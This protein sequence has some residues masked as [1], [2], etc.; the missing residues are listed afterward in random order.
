MAAT[1]IEPGDLERTVRKLALAGGEFADAF[2]EETS[3]AT[4]TFE[5]GKVDKIRRGIDRGVGLRII[6]DRRTLYAYSSE[7]SV[8]ALDEMAGILLSAGRSGLNRT[9][10]VFSA[11]AVN[12][13]S[14]I[15]LNPLSVELAK[16]IALL[17][18]ADEVARSFGEEITQVRC[19]FG[20][21]R[22]RVIQ[23]NSDGMTLEFDRVGLVFVVHVTARRGDLLQTGYEPVGGQVGWELFDRTSPT[24]IASLAASRALMMLAAQQA[25]SGRMPVVLHSDAG[26]TMIHEA[27]GHGLEADFI[28]E[29]MSV[30]A[31]SLG[32]RVASEVVSVADDPTLPNRRGSYPF[33][34]EGTRSQRT[35][36]VEN[37][38]LKGFL[39][40]RLS[41]LKQDTTPTGNGRRES[42]RHKPIPRMSNTMILP[43]TTNP[44]E[45]IRATPT[46]LLVKKMGGGQVDP[47]NGNFVFEVSEGYLIE[48]G[49]QGAPVRGATLVGN[50]PK[51]L[52]SID[53]VGNDL[54]FA[55]G[56]CGKDGQGVPVSD[57]QPTVRI[58]TPDNPDTWI[59][60]GGTS[61]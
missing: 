19:V 9:E 11:A 28:V 36:L 6:R 54:G 23:A 4:L 16:K 10:S 12:P 18:E 24:Q 43:G 1:P 45:I 52:Q 50:G 14:T 5:H 37:G 8:R 30:Y 31:N 33:D 51:V 55:I 61:A 57:A 39:N 53:M 46:G 47:I 34:D 40:D 48:N 2:Y 25:P 42:Y 22:R 20:D 56:T 7:V 60:I 41:A 26:G 49:S 59:T 44:D 35:I 58:G 21:E 38:I 15:G 27:V 17:E 29:K 32:E 13:V 3:G